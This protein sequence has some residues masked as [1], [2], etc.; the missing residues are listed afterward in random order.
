[1]ET[2][3]LPVLDA[4]GQLLEHANIVVEAHMH[5]PEKPQDIQHYIRI[6]TLDGSDRSHTGGLI[7]TDV[8][9][10]VRRGHM[11]G[12]VALMIIGLYDH[13]LDPSIRKAAYIAAKYAEVTKINGKASLPS[14]EADIMKCFRDFRHSSHLWAA[15]VRAPSLFIEA[16]TNLVECAEFLCHAAI[17]LQ[18][19]SGA[20]TPREWSPWYVPDEVQSDVLALAFHPWPQNLIDYAKDYA[21]VR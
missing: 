8:A 4:N 18:S 3:Y 12:Q 7:D 16:E 14:D 6:K 19:L 20:L 1:M 9:K 10:R 2:R 15:Q 21:R 5:F 17:I 13:D 11:A